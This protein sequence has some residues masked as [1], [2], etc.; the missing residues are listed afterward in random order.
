MI[1]EQQKPYLLIGTSLNAIENTMV[2]YI[3]NLYQEISFE[4]LIRLGKVIIIKPTGISGYKKTDLEIP[5]S[6]IAVSQDQPIFFIFY[7]A[8]SLGEII[9]NSLLKLFEEMPINT[10]VFLLSLSRESILPTIQSRC[11]SL[12]C[13]EAPLLGVKDNF[14]TFFIDSSTSALL[15]HEYLVSHDINFQH[16]QQYLYQL[17]NYV[18]D[19]NY[20]KSIIQSFKLCI[21]KN[22]SITIQ[23]LMWKAL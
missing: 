9:S 23:V 7:N 21:M 6:V 17:L 13:E 8:E 18:I 4:T 22:S 2:N 20:E 11:I 12:F 5:R 3:K 15:L 16:S 10:Y 19:K 1:L 14:I